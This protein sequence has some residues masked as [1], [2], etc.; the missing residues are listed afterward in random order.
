MRYLGDHYVSCGLCLRRTGYV[1]WGVRLMVYVLMLSVTLLV[2]LL[3]DAANTAGFL[4]S[5]NRYPDVF[6]DGL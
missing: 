3:I 5:I 4:E 6:P 1:D 2:T